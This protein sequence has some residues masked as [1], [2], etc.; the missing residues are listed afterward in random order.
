MGASPSHDDPF[1]SGGKVSFD[2]EGP[3]EGG[4]G[5]QSPRA[6]NSQ[7]YNTSPLLDQDRAFDGSD[8]VR[9]CHCLCSPN[10]PSCCHPSRGLRFHAH[11]VS[12]E[13]PV[14][15]SPDRPTAMVVTHTSRP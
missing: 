3:N 12:S 13:C 5:G 14:K 9:H 2:D 10:A 15:F 6:H 1:V 8:R 11:Q 4:D 7:A